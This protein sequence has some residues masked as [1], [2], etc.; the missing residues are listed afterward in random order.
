VTSS[1]QNARPSVP[2]ANAL[3]VLRLTVVALAVATTSTGL[4]LGAGV[5]E[6][7][8]TA[9]P[10]GLD[11][12]KWVRNFDAKSLKGKCYSHSNSVKANKWNYTTLTGKV[13]G[14]NTKLVVSRNSKKS[15]LS[16][17]F[18]GHKITGGD[19]AYRHWF[20][21]GK[22]S[23]TRTG[24]VTASF[25]MNGRVY[26]CGTSYRITTKERVTFSQTNFLSAGGNF[27]KNSGFVP[28]DRGR[29]GWALCAVIVAS[30]PYFHIGEP[31]PAPH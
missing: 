28:M 27:D 20:Q 15:K 17:F 21:K 14:R 26:D 5:G 29:Q 18:N 8:A 9:N 22:K 11:S 16:G 3:G 2:A 7:H 6:A 12:C 4:V 30:V 19:L 23:A 24:S 31:A 25:A 13:A 10:V 1:C